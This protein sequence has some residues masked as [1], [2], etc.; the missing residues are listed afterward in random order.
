MT[1]TIITTDSGCNPINKT[2]MIPDVIIEKNNTYYDTIKISQDNIPT[3][4][5]DKVLELVEKGKKITTS[6]PSYED[7]ITIFEKHLKE[8]KDIIHLATSSEISAASCNTPVSIINEL[9]EQYQNNIY[10]ID[11]KTIGSGGTLINL[12]AED[13]TKQNLTAKEI[14]EH[15]EELKNYIYSTYYVK[16]T[17]G[18]RASGKVPYGTKILDILHLRYNVIVNSKG[19]LVPNKIYRGKIN[20]TSLKYIKELINENN[21][22]QYDN[23]Y[24]VLLKTILE[25]INQ[26]EII[27][28]IKSF[29]Y[30]ENIITNHFYSAIT[31]YGVKDQI[32]LALLKKRK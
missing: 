18:Y 26:E 28:Y 3:I 15:L 6:A 13:L 8:N 24:F 27:N 11:T 5:Y 1:K 32:G 9:K 10:L 4:S 21:I 29:N 23:K 22:E 19:Q 31:A 25:Q 30:F 17:S 12:L 16:D 2:N 7:Y 20:T 14:K